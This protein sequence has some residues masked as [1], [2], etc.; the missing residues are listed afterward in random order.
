MEQKGKETLFGVMIDPDL[1]KQ[2]RLVA[3]KHDIKMK[4]L[5]ERLFRLVV[6]ADGVENLEKLFQE[7]K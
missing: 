1:R 5:V 3:F 4:E 6:A 2:V 7:K